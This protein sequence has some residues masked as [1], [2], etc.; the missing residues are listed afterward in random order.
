[1]SV[2][3]STLLRLACCHP[4]TLSPGFVC[5]SRH[6]EGIKNSVRPEPKISAMYVPELDLSQL[7]RFLVNG[8][9]I[10]KMNDLGKR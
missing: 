10:S 4:F 6:A 9:I 1:M 2:L 3:P 8:A 5:N 7:V